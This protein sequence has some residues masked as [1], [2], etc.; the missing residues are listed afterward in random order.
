MKNPFDSTGFDT[1][2]DDPSNYKFVIFYYNKKDSRHVV[3]KLN[4]RLGWTLNFAHPT[5][6]LFIIALAAI[7]AVSVLGLV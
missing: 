2:L 6:Y 5:A 7:I 4:R 1:F 3:P